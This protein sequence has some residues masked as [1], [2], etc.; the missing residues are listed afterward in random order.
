MKALLVALTLA[1]GLVLSVNVNA[2]SSS[3]LY[4][5]APKSICMVQVTTGVYINAGAINKIMRNGKLVEIGYV[6]K[7]YTFDLRYSNEVAADAGLEQL[8][9][10]INNRCN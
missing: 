10:L 5:S 9:G 8:I 6:G 3:N 2:K 7:N 1:V 4:D